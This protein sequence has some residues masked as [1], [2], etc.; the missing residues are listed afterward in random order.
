MVLLVALYEPLRTWLQRSIDTLFFREQM[1]YQERLQAFG[2]ELTQTIEIPAIVRLLRATV[3]EGMH[4][5]QLHIFIR[6]AL[7]GQYVSEPDDNGQPTTDIRFPPDSA[8]VH[9]L[10]IR[11]G[12]IFLGGSDTLPIQLQPERVLAPCST[13]LCLSPARSN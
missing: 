12:C 5:S 10:T 7:S 4:P 13:T 9:T 6:D 8:F 2:R 3:Q 11:R 1:A